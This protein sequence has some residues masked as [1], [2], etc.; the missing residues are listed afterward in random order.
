MKGVYHGDIAPKG[1]LPKSAYQLLTAAQAAWVFGGM[2]SW[3]DLGFQGQDQQTYDKLSE[4]L[5]QLLNA[6][7][8]QATNTSYSGGR[9]KKPW[10]QLWN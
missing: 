7:I 3:N 8:V 4:E 1:L 5:Y 2:G 6:A 9:I 10:W